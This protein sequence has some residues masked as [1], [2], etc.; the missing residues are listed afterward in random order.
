MRPGKNLK[1]CYLLVMGCCLAAGLYYLVVTVPL[2]LNERELDEELVDAVERLAAAGSGMNTA[3]V[4]RNIEL[5]QADIDAFAAIGT[6]PARTIQ[7]S[8]E[9]EEMLGR[10]FHLID[11]DR[12]KFRAVDRI[13]SLSREHQVDLFDDW[14]KKLPSFTSQPPYQLWAQLTVMDQL[15][16]TAIGGGVAS[17]DGAEIILTEGNGGLP[18]GE[19][20]EREVSVRMQLTGKME[21]IHSIIMMLPLNGEE[22]DGLEL[23]GVQGPKSSFFLSRFILK[24]SSAENADE[25]KLDFVASGF[26]DAAPSL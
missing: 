20:Q 17:I 6:D 26:L 22:L 15:L 1:R 23:T 4:M 16:R 21:A 5:L 19:A 18:D 14:E 3:E 10:Q 13:R 9:V 24:K 8:P 25:V 12:S 2:I 7:F 11:F